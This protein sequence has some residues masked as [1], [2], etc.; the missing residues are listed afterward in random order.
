M[1]FP[2]TSFVVFVFNGDI[3]THAPA[4]PTWDEAEE[5]ANSL[6]VATS[7]LVVSEPYPVTPVQEI[8]YKPRVKIED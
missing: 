5:F 6:R 3:G 8:T 7:N 2:V 1:G 4:F